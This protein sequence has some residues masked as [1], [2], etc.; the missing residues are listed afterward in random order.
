[1]PAKPDYIPADSPE[2]Q[3]LNALYAI[4]RDIR[5]TFIDQAIWLEVLATDILASFFCTDKQRRALLSS[6]VL[7]GRDAT[8]S[9]RLEV[10]EKIVKTWF[11]EVAASH[12]SLFDQLGKIRRFRNRLAHSH[13]DTTEAFLS[14]GYTDRIRLVFHEN[15]QEKSQVVTV[16]EFRERLNESSSAFVS[17]QPRDT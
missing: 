15:G 16:T 5:G 8:F 10:L 2:A 17:Q 13:V 11:P 3:Q 1:M 4:V 14:K 12:A 6:D 7:T 9:G